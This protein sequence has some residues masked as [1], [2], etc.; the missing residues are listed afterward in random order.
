MSYP[1]SQRKGKS[2]RGHRRETDE[3][4]GRETSRRVSHSQKGYRVREPSSTRRTGVD[5]PT[6]PR[7]RRGF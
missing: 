7:E 5:Q 2:D 1:K 3:S 4:Y 6:E